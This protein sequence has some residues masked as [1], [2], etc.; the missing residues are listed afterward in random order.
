MV[1]R[2]GRRPIGRVG[3]IQIDCPD[4]ERLAPFWAELLGVEIQGRLGSPPQ[5]VNL[6]RQFPDAP[7][8][9]FQRVA[10]PKVVKNRVHLDIRVEDVNDATSR[11]EAIGGRRRRPEADFMEHGFCWRTMADPEGNEFCLIY[12]CPSP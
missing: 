4:P 2:T 11:I 5:F 9:S 6:E 12:E 10:E 1:T 8:V 7:S 3:W